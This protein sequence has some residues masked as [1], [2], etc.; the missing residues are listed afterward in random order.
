MVSLS[1]RTISWRLSARTP[2]FTLTVS[3]V[4]RKFAQKKYTILYY[5]YIRLACELRVSL[6]TGMM[7]L[8]MAILWLIVVRND[9]SQDKYVSEEERTYLCEVINY[10][11]KENVGFLFEMNYLY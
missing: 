7:I 9:P 1:L 5:Y 10:I 2:Y 8:I 4:R 3:K 11:P 6:I